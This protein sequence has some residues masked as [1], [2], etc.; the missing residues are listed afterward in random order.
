MADKNYIPLKDLEVY[1]LSREFSRIC[2]RIYSKLNFQQK[3]TVGDQF[4]T[5]ADSV[6]ANIAEGYARFHYLDKIR[7]YYISRGS[8][9]EAVNHWS[10][11]M[12]ERDFISPDEFDEVKIIHQKLEVKLNNFISSTFK[13]KHK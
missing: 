13:S 11:I 1:Q 9:S 10:E 2:W 3:K 12:L 5:S 6:G 4:I 8:L 7:F